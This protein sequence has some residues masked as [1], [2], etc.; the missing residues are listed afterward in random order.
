[1]ADIQKKYQEFMEYCNRM[2]E[3]TDGLFYVS[4]QEYYIAEKIELFFK[5]CKQKNNWYWYLTDYNELWTFLW[6]KDWENYETASM[7]A[8]MNFL[9]IIERWTSMRC[10]WVDADFIKHS[11]IL[12][13]IDSQN[14][15]IH[16]KWNII[17]WRYAMFCLFY[18]DDDIEEALNNAF[19]NYVKKIK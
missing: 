11:D 17:K 1:M 15:E 14:I 13:R 9:W 8:F 18:W 10:F 19:D 12:D 4:W 16:E 2:Y 5:Y 6:H 7:L 3:K